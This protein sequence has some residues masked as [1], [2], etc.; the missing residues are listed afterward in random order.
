[1][2]F[3]LCILWQI[4]SSINL[5]PFAAKRDCSRIYLSLPNATTIEI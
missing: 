1:M 4:V 5:D 3:D 2:G